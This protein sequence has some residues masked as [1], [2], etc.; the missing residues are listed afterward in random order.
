MKTVLSVVVLGIGMSA[1]VA[2][3]AADDEKGADKGVG[4]LAER[5][6]D[7]NLTEDQESKIAD[8]RKE[9][10]PKVQEAAKEFQ[11]LAKEEEEK[12]RTVLTDEQK[13]KLAAAK[14]ERKERRAER[15]A[16][17][18][19]HLDELDLT[20]GE[21]AKIAEIR[22]E[23]EPR[24]A[25]AF[26]GLKGILS[27][28]QKKA[29]EEALKADKKRKEIIASLNLTDE[30]KE[31]METAGKE[32]RTIVHE[33]LEKMRDVLSAEQQEK[34]AELKDERR[35]RARDRVACAIANATDLG[36]SDQQKSQISAIRMEYR[37]KIH[38]AGNKLRAAV[39]DEV[40][41]IVAVI[42]G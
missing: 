34:L 8:I 29:R 11:A 23:Y 32:V 19:A 2:L 30:Q 20:E 41:A 3:R 10:K 31:K 17:R 40:G 12:V 25:K 1:Y 13:T 33:E 28:D 18:I 37:P 38:E 4:V 5:L 22:K 16:E 7:L 14:D 6:Q 21:M 36:L 42:K 26:E 27:D 24:V 39:R 35:D 9:C 15:L